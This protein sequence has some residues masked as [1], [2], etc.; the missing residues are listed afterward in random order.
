MHL[1]V[2]KPQKANP[3]RLNAALPVTIIGGGA[4]LKMAIA[5]DFDGQFELRAIE[6]EN[7]LIYA[8]LTTKSV[9]QDLPVAEPEPEAQFGF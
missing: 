5:I 6:I 9:L 7:V 4:G 1:G 8:V 2:G 3:K